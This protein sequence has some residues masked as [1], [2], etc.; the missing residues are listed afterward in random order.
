MNAPLIISAFAAKFEI[1]RDCDCSTSIV[2][3]AI[4]TIKFTKVKKCLLFFLICFLTEKTWSQKT[5]NV[6]YV[7]PTIGGVGILLEPTRPTVHL[8]NSLIRVF[9]VR[10]DQLDDQISYFPLTISSHRQQNLFGIMPFTGAIDLK[11]EKQLFTYD[12]EN[13]KPYY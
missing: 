8:P 10:K 5:S 13:T 4:L 2:I 6:S 9:P 12:A 11:S 7:D 3:K 1:E